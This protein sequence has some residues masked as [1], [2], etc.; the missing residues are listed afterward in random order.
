MSTI[1][2]IEI[3]NI[4]KNNQNISEIAIFK[5][6]K[7]TN[8]LT[9]TEIAIVKISKIIKVLKITEMAIF[10]ITE[11][12]KLLKITETHVFFKSRRHFSAYDRFFQ[13]V[14]CFLL[15]CMF[16]S[17]SREPTLS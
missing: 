14:P 10:K 17:L 2:E 6:T 5:T 11:I 15:K 3:F 4:T 16:P 9:I 1:T 8:I 7:I 13:P 12:I